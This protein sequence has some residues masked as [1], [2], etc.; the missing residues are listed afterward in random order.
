LDRVIV[1]PASFPQD[2]D[3]LQTNQDTMIALGHLAQMV[4]GSA[5]T[6]A[7]GLACNPTVPASLQVTVGTGALLSLEELEA[8]AYGS[9]PA[10]TTDSLMKLGINPTGLTSFTITPPTTA[11]DSIN[12]LIEGTFEEF[13]TDSTVLPYFNVAVPAQAFAGPNNNNISQNTLRRQV[14]ELQ[15]KAGTAAATGTQTTPA[16]DTGFV[17]LFV[18]TVA[19]GQTSITA[20]NITNFNPSSFLAAKLSTLAW[21]GNVAV[22]SGATNALSI[23][24]RPAPSGLT[25]MEFAPFLVKVLD[26]NT[27]ATTVNVNGLGAT[28]AVTP[29]GSALAAGRITAGGIYEFVY[30]GTAFMLLTPNS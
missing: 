18:V 5:F 1:Y 11:G 7:D 25:E 15:L 9:L 26:T 21:R 16:V 12:Y 8:T 6:I 24:L 4:F 19:E 10:D 3:L 30:N 20:G 13:D 22:D 28:A 17:G 2:T 23:S 14:V 27:G 29:N